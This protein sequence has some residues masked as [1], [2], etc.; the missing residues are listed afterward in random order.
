MGV[1][2]W[3][4]NRIGSTEKL[5]DVMADLVDAM[6]TRIYLLQEVAKLPVD[7]FIKG[8]SVLHGDS[9]AAAVVLHEEAARQLRWRHNSDLTSSVL[10]GKLGV[11]SA[12]LAGSGKSMEQ[13][14]ESVM[15]AKSEL[16][17]LRDAGAKYLVVGCDAQV[18]LEPTEFTGPQALGSQRAD[19][20]RHE[21]QCLLFDMLREFGLKAASTW[22]E[23]NPHFTRRPWQKKQR[24]TQLD[25]LFVSKCLDTTSGVHNQRQVGSSDHYP[26][27]C[28][29]H[30]SELTLKP[31]EL[32]P[33]LSGWRVDSEQ[34]S[35]QFRSGVMTALG[36]TGIGSR[37]AKHN[38]TLYDIQRCIEDEGKAA[39]HSTRN[40]R[41]RQLLKKAPELAAAE[42]ASK[43]VGAE[44]QKQCRRREGVLR[45]KWKGQALHE[46]PRRKE[47]IQYLKRGGTLTEDRENWKT[48]LLQHCRDKY[49]SCR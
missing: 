24:C 13:F 47:K 9:C 2:S 26:V 40:S 46:R 17:R 48:E 49:Q 5:E 16:R 36:L 34:S 3:N 39:P 23:S 31:M 30:G 20:A 27:W 21:R 37:D 32:Q 7:P 18:E 41:R 38:I 35:E 11:M 14:E 8:W 4:A 22:T 29:V 15:K 25:Y 19:S 28:D 6:G 1:A 10:I 44:E 43:C 33:S 42:I 45:R 12:Y